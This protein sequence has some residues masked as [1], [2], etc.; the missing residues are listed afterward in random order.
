MGNVYRK[1]RESLG[2]KACLIKNGYCKTQAFY[3]LGITL[4]RRPEPQHG[5]GFFDNL[6]FF[7]REER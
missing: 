5:S 3:F 1:H 7:R 6:L 4:D 2:W